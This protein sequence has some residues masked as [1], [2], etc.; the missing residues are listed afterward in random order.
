MF[1]VVAVSSGAHTRASISWDDTAASPSPYGQSKLAQIMHMRELQ[2]RLS[3]D[4]TLDY[5]S[6]VEAGEEDGDPS[7]P[8]CLAVTPGLVRT[9]MVS[10]M[11]ASWSLPARLAVGL[12][13][14]I[15]MAVSRSLEA[16]AATQVR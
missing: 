14:P 9:G 12:I 16:G 2:R 1:R 11:L 3:T 5:E 8:L 13:Y 10:R 15:F 6:K 4:G 7:R